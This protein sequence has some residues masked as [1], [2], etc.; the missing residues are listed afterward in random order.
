MKQISLIEIIRIMTVSESDDSPQ[1]ILEKIISEKYR[2]F[3]SLYWLIKGY[4]ENIEKITYKET[5]HDT[6]KVKIRI[7]KG[8][9][10]NLWVLDLNK[11]AEERK[12]DV[13]IQCEDDTIIIIIKRDESDLP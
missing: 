12:V 2:K 8:I 1:K 10:Y 6:L 4:A 13:E 11:E 7:K 3:I 9:D 5:N